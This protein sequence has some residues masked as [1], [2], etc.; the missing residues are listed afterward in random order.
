M[1]LASKDDLDSIWNL[2]NCKNTRLRTHI[3][4]SKLF[5]FSIA[6]LQD[7]CGLVYMLLFLVSL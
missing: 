6:S 2:N 4:S 3:L 1:V 5:T 7:G